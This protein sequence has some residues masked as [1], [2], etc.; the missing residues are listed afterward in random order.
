MKSEKAKE[1][2]N[3]IVPNKGNFDYCAEV[4]RLNGSVYMD[5]CKAVELAE[6]EAEERM[7]KELTRWHDPKEELPEYYKAV[8]VKYKLSGLIRIST[9]WLSAGDAGGYLRTIDGTNRI[10]K[11]IIGWREI[12]E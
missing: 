11:N 5:V 6:Q 9:A 2:I 10:I 1:Y 3:C 7:R 4:G 8:E 12:H